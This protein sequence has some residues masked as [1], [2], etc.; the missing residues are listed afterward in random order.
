[1]QLRFRKMVERPDWSLPR[2]VA[3]EITYVPYPID[4]SSVDEGVEPVESPTVSGI[5]WFVARCWTPGGEV[6]NPGVILEAEELLNAEE[7]FRELLRDF[8]L[9][10]LAHRGI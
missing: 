9:E 5:Q 8:C 7:G 6:G 3:L 10:D 2:C 4:G 1:M